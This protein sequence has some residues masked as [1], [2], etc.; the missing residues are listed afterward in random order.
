[1]SFLSGFSGAGKSSAGS[2][3]FGKHSPFKARQGA[4]K[5]I[6]I[7][8]LLSL[9]VMTLSRIGLSLWQF[10]RVN[11]AAGWSHILVQGLR[12]DIA[13]L[14]WLFGIAALGT[15]LFASDKG[16]GLAWR[17]V[18]RLWLTLGLWLIIFLEASSSA[19]IEEY[20]FRPNRP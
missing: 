2:F 10:D 12:V 9:L 16:L 5:A 14:C 18:L 19:F 13:S 3:S 8:S 7:F 20:G 6:L 1:M 11:D 15:A 17:F 4:F